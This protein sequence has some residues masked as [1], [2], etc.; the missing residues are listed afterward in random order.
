M[1]PGGLKADVLPAVESDEIITPEVAPDPEEEDR[2]FREKIMACMI[3]IEPPTEEE[4]AEWCKHPAIEVNLHP[5]LTPEND[6]FYGL[7]WA[8]KINYDESP[9]TRRGRKKGG[10]DA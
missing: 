8:D 2:M 3:P 4:Q 9:K 7:E 5:V 1:K 10:N 6:P